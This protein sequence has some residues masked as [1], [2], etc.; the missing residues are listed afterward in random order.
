MSIQQS[1]KYRNA[2]FRK[3][4]PMICHTNRLSHGNYALGTSSKQMDKEGNGKL[5]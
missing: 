1:P 2:V 3:Y 5:S 4:L